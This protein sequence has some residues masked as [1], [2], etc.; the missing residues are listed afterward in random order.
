MTTKTERGMQMYSGTL[1]VLKRLMMGVLG[2]LGL[3]AL[4]AGQVSA[5]QLP[6]PNLFDAQ[7]ECQRAAGDATIATP[8]VVAMGAMASPLDVLLRGGTTGMVGSTPRELPSGATTTSTYAVFPH[9]ATMPCAGTGGMDGTVTA[10][11]AVAVAEGYTAVRA[12]YDDLVSKEALA[13]TAADALKTARDINP[14]DSAHPT[15]L[16]AHN[17]AQANLKEAQDALAEIS[18]G[19]IYQ[20]GIAEWRAAARVQPAIDAWDTAVGKVT[21]AETTLNAAEY[22]GN[23]NLPNTA[24]IDALTD[25]TTGLLDYS[26]LAAYL[27]DANEGAT[28]NFNAA[29]ALI[30]PMRPTPATDDPADTMEPTPVP[31]AV[32]AIKAKLDSADAA[33][34][35]LGEAIDGNPNELLKAR[36]KE[37][38]RRAIAERNHYRTQYENARADITDLVPDV[39]GMPETQGTQSIASYAAAFDREVATRDAA[40]NALRTAV[41]VREDAS[42]AV[43]AQFQNAESFFDQLVARHTAVEAKARAAAIADGATQAQTDVA[44]AA[45]KA[46][47]D[48]QATR[49]SYQDLTTDTDN[50]ATVLLNS[51]LEGDDSDGDDDGQAL[52]DAVGTTYDKTVENAAAIE[53]LVGT[54][55]EEDGGQVNENTAAIAALTDEDGPVTMNTENIAAN[56][57]G[58]AENKAAVEALTADDGPVTMNTDNIAANTEGV[59]ENKAAVEALTADDGPV[60]MNTDNIAAN[61]TMIDANTDGVA[62]NKTA[63]ETNADGVAANKTATETNADGV[64]ANKTATETNADGVA[65]NKTATETNADGVAAN[66]TATETNADGVA[67]NKTATETN[68]DGVAANKTAT[69]TNADGIAAN[70]TATETN[71]SGIATNVEGIATNVTGIATNVTAIETNA[72]GIATN[73]EG[74][75]TNVTGIA[76]NVTAIETNASGIATN[77]SGIATNVE[78]IATNVTGIAT[79]VTAIETNASGIATNVEGIATNVTGIATNVTAIETNASGIA[80]NVEGIATNVTGIATNVEGIAVN[81]AATE[82][83]A[84]GIATNVTDIA[85]N[86]EGIAVNKAA[87]ETNAT[88]IATNAGNIMTNAGNIMTNAG[89]IVTNAG[90]IVTNADGVAVNKMATETN[91]GNITMNAGGIATNASNITAAEVRIMANEGKITTNTGSIASNKS[92][93]DANAASIGKLGNELRNDLD[94]VRAGVAAS[95]ALAGMPSLDGRGFAVGLGSFDGETAFAAGFLYSTD[96]ASFKIGV[97]SSGGETGASVGGAWQF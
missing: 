92:A 4:T 25:S 45:A 93:I 74:I 76:T 19:S 54:G 29:G 71:A 85:T 60:T 43:Q 12:A 59:A 13:K 79:N 1:T 22:A 47:A 39:D 73:V 28:A 63:T 52:I 31:L 9:G 68:A 66:K 61:K 41:G 75:A 24:L 82:T 62:A 97:T 90:N 83:N 51:L 5:Q 16:A 14:D 7:V 53:E 37:A 17:T 27:G 49:T 18:M 96:R 64:A 36:L 23:V 50:P 21:S 10:A 78:G 72:S 46:L 57:E 38:E 94:V 91:A 30:V 89:N 11:D 95:M 67:A 35:V 84:T 81:K 6:V 77:A 48:A 58:V 2:V 33:V 65:A 88:G 40:E 42:K 8:S 44:A 70:K 34:R 3:G 80:T 69:E 86:V 26:A 55:G 56:T 20:A 87:T 15:T 32:S